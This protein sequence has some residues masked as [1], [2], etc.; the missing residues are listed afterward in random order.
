MRLSICVSIICSVSPSRYSGLL[1]FVV[2]SGWIGL[3]ANGQFV[4]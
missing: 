3:D 2:L 1:E 4:V